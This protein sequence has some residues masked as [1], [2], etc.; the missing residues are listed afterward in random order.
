[1]ATVRDWLRDAMALH[2]GDRDGSFGET[3]EAV[4]PDLSPKQRA[5]VDRGVDT[6]RRFGGMLLA[7]AVGLGKTRV[8]VAIARRITGDVRRRS[9]KTERALFVVPARLRRNW[10]RAVEDVGWQLDRDAEIIS[11]Y[12][13]SRNAY[14]KTPPVV[15]VDEAH[16]FRNPTAKRSRHLAKVIAR[17][18]PVLVTATP[19]CTKR[20][21]LLELLRYFATDDT[22]KALVG[23]GLREAFG[24]DEAGEFDIVELLEN[25]VIRRRTPDFGAAGRPNVAFEVLEYEAGDD[26]RWLW[27]NL[28]GRLEQMEWAATGEHWPRGLLINNLLRMWESGPEALLRCL[29]ELLHF[30]ERW[31]EAAREGRAIERPRF[32]ELFGGVDRRQRVFPFLYG[33]AGE[34]VDSARKQRVESDLRVLEKLRGKVMAVRRTG[35]AMSAAIAGEIA[36]HPQQRYLLFAKYR[37]AA[38]SLF[39]TLSEHPGLRVGLVTG[40]GASATGL[41]AADD[42]EIL[43]R[44]AGGEQWR[45]HERLR[46]L[47]ATDCLSEGINLQGCPNLILADLPYSPVKLEQRIG[48]IAR[49]G[50]ALD[51]VRVVLPRPRSWTDSLGLRRRLG[52]RMEMARRFGSGHLL[53]SAVGDA[54][55]SKRERNHGGPLAA[56]TREERLWCRLRDEAHGGA[57]AFVRAEQMQRAD[58][59]LW[60]RVRIES[61]VTRHVWLWFRDDAKPCVRRSKQVSGLAVLADDERSVEVVEP[62]GSRWERARSW[63]RRRQSVLRAAQLAP[64]LVERGSEPVEIWHRLRDGASGQCIG[65]DADR[66]ERW[67]HRLLWTH[68]PGILSEM[69]ELLDEEPSLKRLMRFADELADPPTSGD[70]DVSAVAALWA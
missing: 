15:V 31:L 17:A 57:P 33:D 12:H 6:L 20:R 48:R 53:A 45:T 67:R 9:G 65:I 58:A 63:M 1:M 25:L 51:R 39:E 16:R 47:V 29:D 24:A 26:E 66:L 35:S 23:M 7:D 69:R 64:P 61:G 3:V 38:E 59:D 52:D 19:V 10:R 68:P 4:G 56:M 11:H 42:R 13:L 2:F 44:F 30:H 62:G 5:A 22:T 27:R 54:E 18:P 43:D 40:D 14:G 46:V 36:D 32:R 60:V 21:D 50:S 41:G 55:G 49:P 70:V 8:A 37:A 28:E 34:P